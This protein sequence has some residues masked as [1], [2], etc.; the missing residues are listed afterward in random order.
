V[1]GGILPVPEGDLTLRVILTGDCQIISALALR[2]LALGRQGHP[3][4]LSLT[5]VRC[6]VRSRSGA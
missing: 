6:A 2:S 5:T 3:C 1:L 4:D